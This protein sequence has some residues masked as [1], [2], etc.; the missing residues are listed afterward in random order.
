[1]AL[2][3]MSV[4]KI[5]GTLKSLRDPG[6]FWFGSDPPHKEDVLRRLLG[7]QDCSDYRLLHL[8]ASMGK[9]A[10]SYSLSST[11]CMICRVPLLIWE[12]INGKSHVK[13]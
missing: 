4:S 12:F 8:R 1:M 13:V 6:M 3:A 5:L 9:E 10:P 11:K 2:K 7:F